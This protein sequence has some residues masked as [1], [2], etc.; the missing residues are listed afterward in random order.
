[1]TKSQHRQTH[2][3]STI[4][5][6]FNDINFL[7]FWENTDQ[8]ENHLINEI[9]FTHQHVNKREIFLS[10]I[11]HFAS[12]GPLYDSVIEADVIHSGENPSNHSPIFA[13]VALNIYSKGV[14]TAESKRKVNWD[15]S[16]ST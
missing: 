2:F 15:K 12:N 5:N 4:K 10:T 9:D 6:F 3:T 1:M 7:L 14:E 8:A 16:T 11:D 13:K